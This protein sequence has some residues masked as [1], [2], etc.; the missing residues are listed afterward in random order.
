MEKEKTGTK[1]SR[2][3]LISRYQH[4][5]K[6]TLKLI[7]PLSEEDCCVQSMGDASPAKWHLAHTSWF[8]ETFLLEKSEVNFQSYKKQYKELF[9]SYYNSVGQQFPRAKRGMITRPSLSEILSYRENVD[10]RV[11]EC[12]QYLDE[13]AFYLIELGLNHEQQ[14][15]ELL[16]MDLKHLFL[17][18]IH[19]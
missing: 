1:F 9:N 8:F 17:S 15:Q 4:I 12:F 3:D 14:H 10:A 19:I 16:L 7:E 2:A 18:L 11:L 6:D 13:S 5:R